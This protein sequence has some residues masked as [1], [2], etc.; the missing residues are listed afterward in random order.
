MILSHLL[1]CSLI[2]LVF[3]LQFLWHCLIFSY[4]L[5]YLA[6][7]AGS[8]LKALLTRIPEFAYAE[9]TRTTQIQFGNRRLQYVAM[10]ERTHKTLLFSIH[11]AHIRT[12]GNIIKHDTTYEHTRT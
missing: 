4:M 11:C 12:Y 7:G 1:V 9:L 2:A 8:I 3:L 10:L 6:V 5:T